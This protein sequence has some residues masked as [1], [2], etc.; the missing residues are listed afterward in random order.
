VFAQPARFS[1]DFGRIPKLEA[2][3]YARIATTIRRIAFPVIRVKLSQFL[4]W[5][6]PDISVC[7]NMPKKGE[8]IS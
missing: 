7:F 3:A 6:F 2:A 5:T 8:K 4:V 1:I